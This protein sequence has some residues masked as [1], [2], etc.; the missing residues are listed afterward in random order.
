MKIIYNLFFHLLIVYG[1]RIVDEGHWDEIVMAR[2][3]YNSPISFVP[4]KKIVSYPHN[5]LPYTPPPRKEKDNPIDLDLIKI[6][7]LHPKLTIQK[8]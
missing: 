8:S 7:T 1:V 5:S 4:Y 2:K 3:C 6:K